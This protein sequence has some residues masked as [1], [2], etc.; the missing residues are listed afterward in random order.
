VCCVD[1]ADAI[2]AFSANPDKFALVIT[3]VDMP[4]IGG[5]ALADSLLKICPDVKLLVMS[6]MSWS[7]PCESGLPTIKEL[8][9]AYLPKPFC[10]EDLLR[11]M[12]GLLHP[13]Q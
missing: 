11:A 6:G 10:A 13:T 5:V 12:N 2:A 7:E 8:V 4:H 3:D 9:H 1:G